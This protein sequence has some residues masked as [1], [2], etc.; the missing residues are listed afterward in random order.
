GTVEQDQLLAQCA[1]D[2]FSAL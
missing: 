2:C 1:L